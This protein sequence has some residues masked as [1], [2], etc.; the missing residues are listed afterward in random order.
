MQTYQTLQQRYLAALQRD[1]KD[2][3]CAATAHQ[4]ALDAA[5]R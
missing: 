2:E 1:P 5:L 4:A 3:A